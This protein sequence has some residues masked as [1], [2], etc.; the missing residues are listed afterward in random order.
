L[1]LPADFDCQKNSDCAEGLVCDF[2]ITEGKDI[3]TVHEPTPTFPPINTPTVPADAVVQVSRGGGC[4]ITDN[5]DGSGAWL[6]T[7]LP[8][9]FWMRRR[10]HVRVRVQGRRGSK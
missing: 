2:D 8:I 1:P 3:C 5:R 10:Q 7:A 9:A 4:S 6:L